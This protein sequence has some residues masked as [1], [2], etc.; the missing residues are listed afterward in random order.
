MQ[1]L[2]RSTPLQLLAILAVAAI[3]IA[4]AMRTPIPNPKWYAYATFVFA[5]PAIVALFVASRGN[6]RAQA[7]QIDEMAVERFNKSVAFASVT[8]IDTM[9]VLLS[10]A[11]GSS[12]RTG[13]IILGVAA[14]WVLLWSPRAL[15]QV[16][17]RTSVV[18]Q[19]DASVVF[20]FISDFENEP[21]YIPGIEVEK[22][23][24][25]P[26][27]SGTQ[28]R[29]RMHLPNGGTF[30]GVEEIVDYE[31]PTR[32]TSRVSSGLRPNF[33]ITTFDPVERGTR[34]RHRFDT[35]LTY[36]SAVIGMGLLRWITAI[37]MWSRRRA[38]WA[39]VKQI[40]ES[41]PLQQSN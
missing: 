40:L 15:R 23:T 14:A 26:V 1:R 5:V 16:G 17:I 25:G 38:A 30:E 39:R 33:D 32:L 35:E 21:L 28:F 31:P 13:L 6:A 19:R 20:A 24:S 18:I 34:L 8:A 37:E 22:I 12:P 4:Y 27:R 11:S 10:G 41:A 3:P 36:P 7:K 2:V 9:A 29:S